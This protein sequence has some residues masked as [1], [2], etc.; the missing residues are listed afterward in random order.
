MNR[1]SRDSSATAGADRAYEASVERL[2]ATWHGHITPATTTSVLRPERTGTVGLEERIRALTARMAPA[3][4]AELE[5][6][7]RQAALRARADAIFRLLTAASALRTWQ[8]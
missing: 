2:S 1:S 7:L 8:P 6:M 4:R 5:R 3:A